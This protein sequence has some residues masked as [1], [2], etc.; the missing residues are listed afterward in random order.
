MRTLRNS[1]LCFAALL[2]AAWLVQAQDLSKYRGFSLGT[3][4]ADVLKLSGQKLADVK[5]IHARPMLIQQFSWWPFSTSGASSAPD[6]V[7]QVLFSFANGEL[8]RIS[9]TYERSSTEG[10]TV[11]DM[12]NSIA[13]KYGPATNIASEADFAPAQAYDQKQTPV[14]SWQNSQ[15]SVDLIR[16]PYGDSFGLMICAKAAA[17]AADLSIAE[18]VKL[19]ELQRPEKEADEKKKKADALELTREKNRQSFRP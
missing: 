18:A 12:V 11:A 14:A 8:Y 5:T 19:E 1:I 16:W 17:A 6:G 2:F 15:Y 10:L 7:Q 9:V 4:L 3:S 13:A